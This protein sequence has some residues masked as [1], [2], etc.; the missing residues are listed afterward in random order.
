MPSGSPE[1]RNWRNENPNGWKVTGRVASFQTG[2]SEAHHLAGNG[3]LEDL[4]ITLD[5][6]EELINKQDR[7][8]WTPLHESVAGRDGNL[9]VVKFLVERGADVNARTIDGRTALRLSKEKH[10]ADHPIVRF[11]EDI[12]AKDLG[13]E[14]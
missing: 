14:L 11:L 7:N 6:Q 2:S 5:T 10:G 1:E 8:L 4:K 3:Y 12:G 13:P 9:Q